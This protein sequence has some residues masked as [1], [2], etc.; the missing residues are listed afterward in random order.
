MRSNLVPVL[1]LSVLASASCVD[2]ADG[3]T[4]RLPLDSALDLAP[5]DTGTLDTG[6]LDDRV[7]D[8][9]VQLSP[10]VPTPGT[11]APSFYSGDALL[12]P[13]AGAY[14][15]ASL[16]LRNDSIADFNDRLGRDAADF[17]V[18][19]DFPMEA[20]DVAFLDSFL[21]QVADTGALAVVTFEPRIPL[22]DITP[23]MAQDL[24]DYL[25]DYNDVYEL[26]VLV[27]FAH[28]MNGSWYHWGQQPTRYIEVYRMVA[29]A[30]H[31]TALRTA[32]LWAPNYGGGYPFPGGEYLAG[33]GSADFDLLDTNQDGALTSADDPYL[34]YYPGDA[35]VDWVGLSL[36]HWGSRFPWGEN[37]IPEPHK[38]ID[39]ITGTYDGL[40]GDQSSV[41]DYYETFTEQRGKPLAVVETGALYNPNLGGASEFDIKSAWWEQVFSPEVLDRFPRLRLLNWFEH[42]KN[43]P[44]V[45]GDVIDWRV[46]ADDDIRE[47][48]LADLPVDRLIFAPV[49]VYDP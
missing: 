42:L 49:P 39:E 26:G 34:P 1:A 22:A 36:Y 45:G 13:A 7:F 37:E 31:S 5:L 11:R 12:E 41:P 48:F 25:A 4:N 23:Q 8:Q 44:E 14:F 33:P 3:A 19:V 46:T 29:D 9:V 47:A 30:I 17:V 43:S 38:F 24:A 20:S 16:N 15:G 27:R 28:E 2:P 40:A 35:Y 6:T 10:S 21:Q 32:M 18:F